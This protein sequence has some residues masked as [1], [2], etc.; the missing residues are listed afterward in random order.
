M[1]RLVIREVSGQLDPPSGE[2][3]VDVLMETKVNGSVRQ[4]IFTV[5]PSTTNREILSQQT[6]V[7][8]D[9]GSTVNVWALRDSTA[10][11]TGT[12][13]ADGSLTVRIGRELPLIEAETAH[14]D[15]EG[16][17]TTGKVLLIP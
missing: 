11:I 5:T 9:P 10:G 8:A 16:R 6:E 3:I 1:K 17:R 13:V 2:H 15:L 12:N 7:Y 4:A 14:R